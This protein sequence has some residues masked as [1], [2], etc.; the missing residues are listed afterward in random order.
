VKL[1]QGEE[2]TELRKFYYQHGILFSIWAQHSELPDKVSTLLHDFRHHGE[3]HN[4]SL[5]KRKVDEI[6]ALGQGKVESMLVMDA[7]RTL[8]AQDRGALFWKIVSD[9]RQPMD[10]ESPLKTLFNSPLG[11]SYTAFRQAALLYREMGDEQEFDA[12]CES[13]HRLLF[14]KIPPPVCLGVWRQSVRFVNVEKG[15]SSHCTRHRRAKQE[16][17]HRRRTFK[18]HRQRRSFSTTGFASKQCFAASKY[19]QAPRSPTQ[20]S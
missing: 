19:Y 18:G 12:L 6:V 13:C 14:T 2:K 17:D 9:S 8:A 1:G 20:E 7:D 11:H 3:E 5:A 16:Q 4:L 10:D 15:R